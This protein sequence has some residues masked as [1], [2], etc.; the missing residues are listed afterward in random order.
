[1][2]I[3]IK[4][5]A[6]KDN[7]LYPFFSFLFVL[8]SIHISINSLFNEHNY[9][10]S[11]YSSIGKIFSFIPYLI[12]L[13]Q[14]RNSMHISK[15]QEKKPNPKPKHKK[16]Y[17]S[18]K[19][20]LVYNDQYK[21]ISYIKGYHYLLLS[22][23]EFLQCLSLFIFASYFSSN[24]S[25]FFWTADII[26]LYI[27]SKCFLKV[28]I[29][30][31]HIL[32]LCIFMIFDIYVTYTTLFGPNYNLWQ[33]LY[34]ILNNCLYSLKVVYAKYLMDYHFISHYKLCLIIGVI[35]LFFGILS[36]TIITILDVKLEIPKEFKFLMDNILTYFY[37][38]INENAFSIIKEIILIISYMITHSASY[39]F[40]FITISNLSPF[41][42]MLIKILISI[43]YN[44]VIVIFQ[45]NY[46]NIINLCIYGLSILVL[47]LFLEILQL[48]C[49]NLNKNT[50]DQ[51]QERSK[52]KK[53]TLLS[54]DK[55]IDDSGSI[56][57]PSED[58]SMSSQ[59]NNNNNSIN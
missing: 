4:C 3:T 54:N 37:K 34:I 49:C 35:T 1:M 18:L 2:C 17:K 41:H 46:I 38:I 25:V 48:N 47:F 40:L 51:I 44:I 13:R 16:N 59:S 19:V 53:D 52:E 45:L 58:Y 26:S 23:I 33:I 7:S 6:I 42:V 12:M 22:L 29:H 21:E 57:N 10:K 27:F 14:S 55:S 8:I 39:I 32:S 28:S 15:D 5:R 43:E 11:V 20:D 24:V 31:H 36:L 30:R 50:K 9:L 56:S